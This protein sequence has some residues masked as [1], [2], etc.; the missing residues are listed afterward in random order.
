MSERELNG[1]NGKGNES[2][3][4]NCYVPVKRRRELAAKR[5]AELAARRGSL[6]L[7]AAAANSIRSGK[8]DGA[9]PSDENEGTMGPGSKLTLLDQ[10]RDLQKLQ[11]GFKQTQL[12]KLAEEEAKIMADLQEKKALL[13]VKELAK[14]VRYTE[15]MKSSWTAPR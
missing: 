10:A 8:G 6:S 9:Q 3:D 5:V 7:Q 11:E 2:P 13:A 12:E 4:E 1:S 15:P 14:D